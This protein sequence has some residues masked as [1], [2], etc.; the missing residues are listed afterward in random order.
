MCGGGACLGGRGRRVGCGP[1]PAAPQRVPPSSAPRPCRARWDPVSPEPPRLLRNRS[2]SKRHGSA[3]TVSKP[4]PGLEA[5]GPYQRLPADDEQSARPTALGQPHFLV[6][7]AVSPRHQRDLV[8]EAFGWEV[9]RRAEHRGRPVPQLQEG[10]GK[11]A[12]TP[13]DLEKSVG[14][15]THTHVHTPEREANGRGRGWRALREKPPETFLASTA[16]GTRAGQV[17]AV[18]SAVRITHEPIQHVG[19]SQRPR[20]G[21]CLNTTRT[22]FCF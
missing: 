1:M 9:R 8:A 4:N 22:S 7:G 6:E 14:G 18:A 5:P 2:P 15:R 19:G 20:Q 10:L 12:L 13:P 21:L 16:N 3:A 11:G 17:G